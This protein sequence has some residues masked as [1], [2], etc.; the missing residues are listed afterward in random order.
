MCSDSHTFSSSYFHIIQH[1]NCAW[2]KGEMGAGGDRSASAACH[3]AGPVDRRIA[4]ADRSGKKRR[5]S[6]RTNQSGRV[7]ASY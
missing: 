7:A 1:Q 5:R 4:G 6:G 2:G 3:D